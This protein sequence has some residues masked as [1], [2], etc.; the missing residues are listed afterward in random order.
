MRSS[1][2]ARAAKLELPVN[3][4]ALRMRGAWCVP[5]EGTLPE[6]LQD[7]TLQLVSEKHVKDYCSISS[8]TKS[9]LS[10]TE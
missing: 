9:L 4:Q 10:H 1:Y 6:G 2:A 5:A 3:F 7:W 8:D